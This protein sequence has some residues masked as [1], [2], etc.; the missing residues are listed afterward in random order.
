MP[1]L[2]GRFLLC[3]LLRNILD[4]NT[5][6]QIGSVMGTDLARRIVKVRDNFSYLAFIDGSHQEQATVFEKFTQKGLI[7]DPLV[8][9]REP[10]YSWY[11]VPEDYGVIHKW[12]ES[13][14]EELLHDV[15]LR[16]SSVKSYFEGIKEDYKTVPYQKRFHG[17][18]YQETRSVTT[19]R[20]FKSLWLTGGCCYSY[21][22]TIYV[23][24]HDFRII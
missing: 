6:T 22:I 19:I 17:G 12:D 3:G 5:A 23:E 20:L 2:A 10:A 11:D 21:T 9:S 8:S 1:R 18:L 14:I 16:G 7:G 15:A 24:K 4:C 13:E